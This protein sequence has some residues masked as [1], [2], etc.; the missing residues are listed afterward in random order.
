MKNASA[1]YFFYSFLVIKL[2]FH[3]TNHVVSFILK[4]DYFVL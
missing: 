1:P 3:L 4:I 2:S